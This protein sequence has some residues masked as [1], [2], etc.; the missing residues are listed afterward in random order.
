[1]KAFSS[2]RP[3]VPPPGAG[4]FA[5]S[6]A[7]RADV[8]GVLDHGHGQPGVGGH[9]FVVLVSAGRL[10]LVVE[11]LRTTAG[12]SQLG[13]VDVGEK[14]A[15]LSWLA[16]A[17]GA[18][19]LLRAG[20]ALPSLHRAHRESGAHQPQ[21]LGGHGDGMQR[22]LPPPGCALRRSC[23][24]WLRSIA[25]GG[26]AGRPLALGSRSAALAGAAA[27]WPI[28]YRLPFCHSTTVGGRLR[29]SQ[30][31]SQPCGPHPAS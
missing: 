11:A 14:M 22:L 15:V 12:L 1:M 20:H 10:P 8:A 13:V 27:G 16:G 5:V 28:S 29:P 19:R 6:G 23:C 7:G 17:E 25:E 30:L 2:A 24:S 21:I 31:C 4:V 18:A 26:R 9:V 3:L